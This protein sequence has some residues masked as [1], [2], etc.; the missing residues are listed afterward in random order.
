MKNSALVALVVLVAVLV[1]LGVLFLVKGP[2]PAVSFFPSSG[3][4]SSKQAITLT[5]KAA[6]GV[7]EV[8]VL[9]LQGGTER[10]VVER[11]YPSGNKEVKESFTL[12]GAGFQDGPVTVVVKVRDRSFTHFGRGNRLAVS[13]AYVLDNK[14]PQVAVLSTA[15]NV[16]RGGVGL[17]V[18]SSTKELSKSG[19]VF[20]DRFFPGYRQK[21]GSY[22]C[23]FPFPYNLPQEQFVPKVLGVDQAGNERRVGIY[24]HLI[25]KRFR[26]DRIELT[27]AFLDK[28]AAEFKDKF[29]KALSPL[30]IFVKANSEE[31]L[32]NLKT[33]HDMGLKTAAEPLWKDIFL[34]FPNSAPRGSFAQERVYVYRGK[35]VD[36]Q[37]HLGV[38][39]ASLPHSPVPA[40]NAGQVVYADDLG[41]YGECVIID[42]GM[43][44]QSLYGHLSQIGVKVGDK[45]EK[46]TVIGRTGDT[47]LAGGDHLHFG[48]L[49]SGEQVNP[50]EW[51][52]G[53][54]IADNIYLKLND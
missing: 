39:L 7:K 45:V 18:Y 2:V 9:A 22:A 27:D 29:P 42:H 43:G 32:R 4:V 48:M 49:V 33:L 51:W 31:R 11:R 28:V 35:E 30:E 50:I 47:G 52:D 15:H 25:P 12:A 10:P 24:F 54:W 5:V 13:K 17:V 38:D 8:S 40:A 21:N 36:R 20:A 6:P 34:R 41:I 44:L 46:R 16:S 3:P 26:S 1:L 23:L 37:T 53:K 19:V 14:P